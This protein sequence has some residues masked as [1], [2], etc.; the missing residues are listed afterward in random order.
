MHIDGSK[1]G[2]TDEQAQGR[3]LVETYK[4]YFAAGVERCYSFMAADEP[5]SNG[6]LWQTS[7][8]LRNKSNNWQEKP[9]WYAMKNYVN[10]LKENKK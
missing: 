3:L 9:A 1:Y 8:I 2:T 10:S 7:G 6:G 5:G 4:A